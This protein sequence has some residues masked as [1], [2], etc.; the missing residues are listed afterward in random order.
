MRADFSAVRF[1]VV[2]AGEI[3]AEGWSHRAAAAAVGGF[4]RGLEAV[5]ARTAGADLDQRADHGAHL[6][7]QERERARFDENLIAVARDIEAVEGADWRIRLALGVAEGREIV[8]ADQRLRGVVHRRGVEA[9][10]HPPGA[11]AI[12]RERR[13]AVDDA[14]EIVAGAGA[15]SGVEIGVHALGLENRD[16]MGM[17]QRVETLAEAERLPCAF[18]VDMRDLAQRMHAGV[19]APRAVGDR[20]LGGH[21]EQRVLERLLD[22][23]AVLLPLPA[24]EWRAVIFED[25]PEAR[26]PGCLRAGQTRGKAPQSKQAELG[27]GVTRFTRGPPEEVGA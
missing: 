15:A 1:D 26:H 4:E 21:R 3:E 27:A 13:A 24:D 9:R 19:G 11:A 16:R 22:R 23:K 14:I 6:P 12:E 20:A 18:K 10:L 7:V 25:E 2:H 17:K 5:A 8:L